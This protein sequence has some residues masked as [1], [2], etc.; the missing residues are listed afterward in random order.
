MTQTIE[1]IDEPR[2]DSDVAYRVEFLGKFMGFGPADIANVHEAAAHLA[3]VVPA[4]VDA[5]YNQLFRFDATKRHF[6][7]RQHGYEGQ[8]PA[9]I[10]SLALDHDQIA[11]RKQHLANYLVKL[12]TAPYDGR[13]LQYLDW[14]GRIHT[15]K[16]GNPAIVVPLV[17]IDALFGFVNDALIATLQGLAVEQAKKDAYV[18][19]FTK[20]L[21]IQADLFNRHY[22]S[23]D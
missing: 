2:L 15:A 16:A 19:S 4:L 10:E 21:W 1:H 11:F 6:V 17:Q 22:V 3:P 18:R 7:P 12:V 5:V 23:A 9:S 14:V 20:L 8:T 13:M